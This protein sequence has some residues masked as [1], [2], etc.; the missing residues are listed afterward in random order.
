[1]FCAIQYSIGVNPPWDCTI[2]YMRELS[3]FL[4]SSLHRKKRFTSFPSPAGMLLTKLPLGRNNSV[5]MSLFPPMESLVVTSW[6][7]MGN[8]PTFFLWCVA[9]RRIPTR[10]V[11]LAEGR[12]AKCWAIAHP[13]KKFSTNF[14][15]WTVHCRIWI[16]V[17]KGSRDS[18]PQPR[19]HY[20]TL[21][22]RE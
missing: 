13:Q 8:S 5:M 4:S 18:H 20:Q 9:Q 17:K 1:M 11:L 15:Y 12:R 16:P 14:L 22:G 2:I 6:L 10:W 21:P 3:I 19:C 7:G